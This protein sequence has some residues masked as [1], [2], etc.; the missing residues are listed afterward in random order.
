MGR[1]LGLGAGRLISVTQPA[2][3]AKELRLELGVVR[4]ISELWPGQLALAVVH[5][6]S[7]RQAVEHRSGFEVVRP[8]SLKRESPLRRQVD[9]RGSE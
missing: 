4:P 2:Q 5:Q 6:I 3:K 7:V 1:E 8:I 9:H